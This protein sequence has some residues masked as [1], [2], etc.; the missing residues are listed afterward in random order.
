MAQGNEEKNSKFDTAENNTLNALHQQTIGLLQMTRRC[1]ISDICQQI[2]NKGQKKQFQRMPK[3][4]LF[5]Y[6]VTFYSETFTFL[7]EQ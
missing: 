6:Q 3:P 5:S 7:H 4:H 1:K 2:T